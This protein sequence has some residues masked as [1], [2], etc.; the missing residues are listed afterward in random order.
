LRRP[1]GRHRRE[2]L[3]DAPALQ[4]RLD[5]LNKLERELNG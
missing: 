4:Q 2:A 1:G 3:L 5:A